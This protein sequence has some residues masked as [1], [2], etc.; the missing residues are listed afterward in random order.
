VGPSARGLGLAAV[1]GIVR[2]HGGGIRVRSTPGA[3]AHFRVLLPLAEA[4]AASEPS[5][6]VP[7]SWRGK[8]TVLVVD[9]DS[10]VRAALAALLEVL[11]FDVLRAEDGA[12]GL[13]RVAE[14][15][16]LRLIVVD[17]RMP[18]M[19][20]PDVAREV[21]RIRPDL[22]VIL[23]SGDEGSS[24]SAHRDEKAAFLRKPFTMP[25]LVK[26]VRAALASR[27]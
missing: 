13:A 27:A 16:E 18:G 15:P 11:G 21:R 25:E 5:V 1:V 26:A 20:G 3:G 12:S 8:G 10:G 2:G 14:N 7:D 9:D 22:P 23:A 19:T 6:R 4:E 24:A 17:M